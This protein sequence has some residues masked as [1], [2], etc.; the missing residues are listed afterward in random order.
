MKKGEISNF[1]D[2]NTAIATHRALV[3]AFASPV[4]MGRFYLA[5]LERKL[6]LTQAA[7]SNDL[8]VSPS[9]V[10][11]SIAA[12]LLPVPILRS[13]S[14]EDHVTFET[15]GAISKLIRQ[16][17]KQLVTNRARSVPLGSSP[18]VVR[19]ILLSGN[20][21]IESTRNGGA[22]SMNLSVC[23]G[24]GRRY[25]RMDSPNIDRI[26]PYLRD[27]EI[28]VNTFLPSLLKR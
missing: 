10:S 15:A 17:G 2:L 24:H 18:D 20:G 4:R 22:I 13:F 8:K 3:A 28:L 1:P 16:C 25:V 12:A 19:S 23:R 6:W 7:L 11:R 21:Q 26:V 14:D 27:L 9:K 5:V